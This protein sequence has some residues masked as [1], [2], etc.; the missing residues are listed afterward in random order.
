LGFRNDDLA[1]ARAL[2]GKPSGVRVGGVDFRK[3]VEVCAKTLG[4]QTIPDLLEL[5]RPVYL[6]GPLS[7]IGFKNA[8]SS[9]SSY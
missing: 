7:I 3:I 4:C 9:L 5:E 6:L 2:F 8:H 1:L